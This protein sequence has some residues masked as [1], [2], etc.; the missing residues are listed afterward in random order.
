MTRQETR[1]EITTRSVPVVLD[2]HKADQKRPAR[3]ATKKSTPKKTGLGLRTAKV[4]RQHGRGLE[5]T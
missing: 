4:V 5:V 3:K 2:E 1:E